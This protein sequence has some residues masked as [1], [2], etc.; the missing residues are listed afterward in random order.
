MAA[1]LETSNRRRILILGGNGM[2][3]RTCADEL[4]K[5]AAFDVDQTRRQPSGNALVVDVKDD[6]RPLW[7]LIR[8]KRYDLV[9]NCVGVLRD[10]ISAHRLLEGIYVNAVFPHQLAD[11]AGDV[12]SRVVHISTDAV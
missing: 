12:G 9:V 11:Q 10:D 1:K 8:E 3:G 7:S 4:G 5:Q 2:L 6:P